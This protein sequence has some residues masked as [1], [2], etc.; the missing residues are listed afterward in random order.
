[1][2]VILVI[3]LIL[4]YSSPGLVKN[5]EDNSL[6]S[7]SQSPT[8]QQSKIFFGVLPDAAPIS[9]LDGTIEISLLMSLKIEQIL[10][11]K[12]NINNLLN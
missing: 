8:N 3:F 11:L 4:F 6:L 10:L 2:T 9:N 1:M 5:F 7:I 12:T